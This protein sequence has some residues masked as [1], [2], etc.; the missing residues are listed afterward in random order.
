MVLQ[1]HHLKHLYHSY[2]LIEF[3]DVQ[4]NDR[5]RLQ[6]GVRKEDTTLFADAFGGNTL[7]GTSNAVSQDY[8]DTLPSA[9]IT[10]EFVNDM[11]VRVAWSETVNRPSLLEITGTTI[12]NPEDSNL[13]RGNVFLQPAE[14]ENLDL[15]WEYYFG[16]EDSLSIGWFTKDFT[17]PIEIGKVQAQNDIFTWFNADTAELDGVEIELRKALY[18][19]EW[20]GWDEYFDGFAL[21]ANVSFIDSE[22]VLL[23][24]GETAGNVPL[25]GGRQI[26]RLFENNRS[27]TGQSD[28]LGNLIVSYT[29]YELGLEGSLAYNY[30]GERVIL[31]G[32]ENAPDIIEE[33]RGKLDLLIKYMVRFWDTDFELEFKVQNITDEEVEWT[34]GGLPYELYD[35]GVGYSLGIKVNLE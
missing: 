26:A 12:R 31:V 29:S 6:G 30:T 20:F 23:G 18:F 15:R 11:Q 3:L 28:F 35:P 25:T 22:V 9:S 33:S 16:D 32:A 4:L 10:Y 7:Q 14:V 2:Y 34:Q 17:D 19:G 27:L 21:S 8:S 1:Y 5:I 24:S 13:Y